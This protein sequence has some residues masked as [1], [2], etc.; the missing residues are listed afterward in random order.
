MLNQLNVQTRLMALAAFPLVVL[1]LLCLLS[2]NNMRQLANGVESLYVDRIEPLQQIKQVSDA[3][4]VTIV[5]TLHKYR[6]GDIGS[7]QALETID[8]ARQTALSRWQAYQQTSLTPEE[9][10]LMEQAQTKIQLWQQ[11]LDGYVLQIRSG[12]LK[13][14]S[15]ET[16]NSAMYA[17][18][19]P[20]SGN[21]EQLIELQ[22]RESRLFK[23]H[24]SERFDAMFWMFTSLAAVVALGLCVMAWLIGR[25]I[26]LPLLSLRKTIVAVGDESDLRLR[27]RVTGRDEIAETAE[28][29]NLMLSK[30][31]A[32][33][34]QLGGCSEQLADASSQMAG[35]SQQV[36]QTALEQEQQVNSI[37]TAVNQMSCA[38]QEVA[39][40][41][42]STSDKA[43]QADSDA[44]QGRNIVQQNLAAMADLSKL[45][46]Q[47]ESVINQL[48]Q[49]SGKIG[50]VLTVIQTIAE[51]TNLL[52]LNA[53]IEAARAGEAGRGFAV[54]AD[55]VRTLANNTHK[56][57]G[58]I[59]Q[60]IDQLQ[61]AA[62]HAVDVTSLS[63]KQ[64]ENSVQHAQAAGK[65]LE[66]IRDAVG[67]IANMNVQ[68]SAAT[69]QQTVVSD[70]INHNISDFTLSIAEVTR[71]AQKGANV[72]ETLASL[73]KELKQKTLSFHF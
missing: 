20:L 47:A 12:E 16:F 4:A 55:E 35:L 42:L 45:V 65:T 13:Q 2:L 18:A 71:S 30:L 46:G 8:K 25:S 26:A 39:S 69:E 73:A 54:V 61:Q 34:Q 43:A 48:N 7:E 56:A 1:M 51:Q 70:E 14:Q 17:V 52:A 53:A 40:T 32:F 24:A 68:I 15:A 50:Q 44:G 57:T 49:E 19:D 66:H 41:A 3:F 29:F 21:L 72:S 33:M 6:A 37:A 10:G 5:D 64:A 63:N 62:K 22:L 59:Q 60:M 9:H 38:I 58:S 27:A 23:E 11:Q 28:S 31:Q 36:S 67:Q